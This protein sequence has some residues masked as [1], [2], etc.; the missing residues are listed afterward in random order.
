MND[1]HISPNCE[2]KKIVYEGKPHLCLFAVKEISTD[3]EITYSYGDSFYPW[4]L[5]VGV[6]IKVCI[7][8]S[9]TKKLM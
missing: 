7:S 5:T 6:F 8:L 9:G 1:D 2:M 4:R 3:E